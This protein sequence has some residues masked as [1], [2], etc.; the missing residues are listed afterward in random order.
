MVNGFVY[1]IK[2]LNKFYSDFIN[3][4]LLFIVSLF[5][6]YNIFTVRQELSCTTPCT[7][8]MFVALD[9]IVIS[10]LYIHLNQG[11]N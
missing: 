7:L 4:M 5:Y 3:C 8:C 2:S 1:F 10:F 11:V 9:Q 6:Y